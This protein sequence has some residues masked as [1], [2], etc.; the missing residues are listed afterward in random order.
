MRFCIFCAAPASSKED[1]W[2]LWLLRQIRTNVP[3]RID[4]ERGTQPLRSWRVV[5][6]GLTVR[7]VCA[8]CNNGWMSEL[9]N[10][11]K[12]IVLRLLD[13]TGTNLTVEEQ[14][15]LAAWAVKNAMVFEALR[16]GQPWFFSDGE[17][18]AFRES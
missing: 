8:P 7:F 13:N 17:R 16:I 9:E 5:G 14:T 3:A 2:P 11:V 6:A 4:A 15:T 18:N 1:A 10:R 12:P